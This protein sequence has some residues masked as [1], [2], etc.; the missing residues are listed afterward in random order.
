MYLF[1]FIDT[2]YKYLRKSDGIFGMKLIFK[3]ARSFHF[4]FWDGR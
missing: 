4:K 3:E 2:V 1:M